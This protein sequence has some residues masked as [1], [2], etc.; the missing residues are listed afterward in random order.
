MVGSLSLVF[1]ASFVNAYMMNHHYHKENNLHVKYNHKFFCFCWKRIDWPNN[2]WPTCHQL[3]LNYLLKIKVPPRKLENDKQYSPITDKTLCSI[4][5]LRDLNLNHIPEPVAKK[6]N[7]KYFSCT[8][9]HQ[10]WFQRGCTRITNQRVTNL[11]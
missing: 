3:H 5:G 11:V 7:P 10:K 1:E 8:C 2:Y 6:K 4:T 9:G